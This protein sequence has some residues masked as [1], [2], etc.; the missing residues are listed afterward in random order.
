MSE[1]LRKNKNRITQYFVST[2]WILNTK[3]I[4]YKYLK[5]IW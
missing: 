5:I 1:S 3:A 4:V 2:S